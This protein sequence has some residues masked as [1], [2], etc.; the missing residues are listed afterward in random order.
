[1][2]RCYALNGGASIECTV[3]VIDDDYG[4]SGVILLAADGE[5]RESLPLKLR[6]I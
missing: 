6:G 3:T 5:L 1:M 4:A 2:P